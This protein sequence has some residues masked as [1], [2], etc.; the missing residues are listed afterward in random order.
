ME[1]DNLSK[2]GFSEALEL[3]AI[4]G[5]KL[6]EEKTA[7]SEHLVGRSELAAGAEY[8]NRDTQLINFTSE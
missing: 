1:A 3:L 8:P 2:S 6:R 4:R 7:N 5:R